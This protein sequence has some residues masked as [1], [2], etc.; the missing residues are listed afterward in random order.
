MPA[1]VAARADARDG[2]YERNP[3]DAVQAV[4]RHSGGDGRGARLVRCT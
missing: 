3:V 1:L 2:G 4:S